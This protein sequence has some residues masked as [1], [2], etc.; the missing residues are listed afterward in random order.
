MPF[1]E[2][3]H[4]ESTSQSHT[5]Q[6]LCCVK[7]SRK[8]FAYFPS[9]IFF[10][11]KEVWIK[12][13]S[14]PLQ[15]S[16]VCLT[17]FFSNSSS[18]IVFT[19]MPHHESALWCVNVAWYITAAIHGCLTCKLWDWKLIPAAGLAA[20]NLV[21]FTVLHSSSCV[22][23]GCISC[24]SPWNLITGRLYNYIL[25][26]LYLPFACSVITCRCGQSLVCCGSD[27][28]SKALGQHTQYKD[29]LK[30]RRIRL[31]LFIIW[32]CVIT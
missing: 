22:F 27:V 11:Q 4:G 31:I 26:F 8:H 23:I 19:Y 29:L 5:M 21:V 1:R 32:I 2:V 13:L 20:F 6:R 28:A 25:C 12:S 7:C 30:R 9:Y 15:G 17:G 3:F 16:S 14:R 10:L 24:Q 18:F